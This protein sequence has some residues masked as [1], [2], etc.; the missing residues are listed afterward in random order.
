MPAASLGFASDLFGIQRESP[1]H[2]CPG[3]VWVLWLH[4][5]NLG[6]LVLDLPSP[7]GDGRE[8]GGADLEPKSLSYGRATGRCHHFRML[9]AP[10]IQ[11]RCPRELWGRQHPQS[12]AAPV[13]PGAR[14]LEN[15][16]TNPCFFGAL[17]SKS[18][19]FG[20]RLP[21]Q[22]VTGNLFPGAVI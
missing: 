8:A 19:W 10:E 17:C 16:S 22:H 1:K 7:S 15:Q 20:K 14:H 21:S 11:P 2:F 3:G 13:T 6:M 18:V 4:L 9:S 5:L 12:V